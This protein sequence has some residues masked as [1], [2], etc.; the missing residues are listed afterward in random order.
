MILVFSKNLD[1]LKG[2]LGLRVPGSEE[3]ALKR[4]KNCT[5]K[6]VIHEKFPW[7]LR[8]WVALGFMG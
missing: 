8:K 5:S 1:F 7:E 2:E 3:G 4:A 6:F